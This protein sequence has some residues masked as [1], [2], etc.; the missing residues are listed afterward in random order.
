MPEW[1]G[2][3]FEAEQGVMP[4]CKSER[5]LA[6]VSTVRYHAGDRHASFLADFL[7][8]YAIAFPICPL[9]ATKMRV[10]LLRAYN[11]HFGCTCYHPLFV[12]NQL[13]DV[14]R[15][16][17]RPGNVHS[18]DGWHAVLEPVIA[19]YRGTVKRLYFRGDA[20]FANPEI[21]EFIEA[22][23]MGYTIRLPANSVL[24]DRIGYLL[25]RPVGRP[26]LEVRRYYASF[27]Y[28]AKSWRKPRRVVAKVEWHPGELYPRVGFIV[29]NLSRP[30]ER[31]VAFYNQRGTC[32]HGSK[33][34]R[35]RS[36]GLGCHA[37][38]SPPTRSAFSSTRSPT[39]S[40][41]SCARW[42]C[43]RQRSRGR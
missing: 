22:E 2:L 36:N 28:Q 31:I 5:A 16:A 10:P 8:N 1:G 4:F 21:Y 26:P 23:G 11:G 12:F 18:A 39:A 41:T 32:E 24:Q 17:L 14:E 13:G 25:K 29:T 34:A 35:A 7:G 19:R 40:A 38:L 20:A 9:Y 30:A 42:R 37:V 33:R 27:S 3:A 6:R 15:C 43:R